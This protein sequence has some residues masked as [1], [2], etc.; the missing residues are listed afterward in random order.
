MGRREGHYFWDV[1]ERRLFD[2][3]INGGSFD[4]GHRNPELKSLCE[5]RH[6]VGAA[7]S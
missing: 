3:H 1:D 2:V 7:E 4:L 5:E 6:G